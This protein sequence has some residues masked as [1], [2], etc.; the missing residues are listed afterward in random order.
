MAAD[1]DEDEMDAIIHM[2]LR[3]LDDHDH[4]PT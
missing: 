4:E 1:E 2:P 3:D